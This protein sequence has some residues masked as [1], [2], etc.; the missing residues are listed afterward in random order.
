MA[1]VANHSIHLEDVI[2]G[3]ELSMGFSTMPVGIDPDPE[4]D[5]DGYGILH[6][7]FLGSQVRRD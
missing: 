5:K 1:W 2:L 4:L 3:Y 7:R 6:N